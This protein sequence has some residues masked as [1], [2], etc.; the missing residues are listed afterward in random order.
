MATN[1]SSSSATATAPAKWYG[2]S[3]KD[4]RVPWLAQTSQL[5]LGSS[6]TR[7]LKLEAAVLI[8]SCFTILQIIEAS[9]G[10]AIPAI[11]THWMDCQRYWLRSVGNE[12]L[13]G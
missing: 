9:N 13:V 6:E 8:P 4:T 2:C 10:Y 5:K 12:R 1:N 7:N 11:R 3:L